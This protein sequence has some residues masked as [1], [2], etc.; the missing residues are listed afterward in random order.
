MSVEHVVVDSAGG[1]D[2][3]GQDDIEVFH[4]VLIAA[5]GTCT[6]QDLTAIILQSS[7]A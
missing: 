4:I 6:H 1:A 2:R 3:L 5:G 7:V